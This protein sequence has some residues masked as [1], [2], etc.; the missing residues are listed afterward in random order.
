[1]EARNGV[2]ERGLPIRGK[3]YTLEKAGHFLNAHYLPEIE[4]RQAYARHD[5]DGRP[6]RTAR[7]STST[8]RA[9]PR[10]SCP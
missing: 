1:M 10:N 7:A 6:R 2:L 9:V 8:C 4:A 3:V 5:A